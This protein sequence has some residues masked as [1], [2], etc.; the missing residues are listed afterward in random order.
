M[1]KIKVFA[2]VLMSPARENIIVVAVFPII[3][4]ITSCLPVS[5]TPNM[6]KAMTG[7]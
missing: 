6:R 5:L 2:I 4:K 7:Q 1:K 3:G